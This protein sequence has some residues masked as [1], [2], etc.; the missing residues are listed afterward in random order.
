[1]EWNDRW[2]RIGTSAMEE[3]EEKEEEEDWR[4]VEGMILGDDVA[5][6][7]TRN[8]DESHDSALVEKSRHTLFD[9]P[10]LN[11]AGIAGR[12]SSTWWTWEDGMRGRW[13][14]RSFP[15]V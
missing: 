1:M 10:C 4:E 12:T 8:A 9:A 3:R 11:I 2:G 15:E 5:P 7:K 6:P 14:N 13:R